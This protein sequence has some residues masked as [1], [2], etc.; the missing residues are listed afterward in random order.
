L[1]L[2]GEVRNSPEKSDFEIHRQDIDRHRVV[3][4]SGAHGIYGAEEEVRFDI[5]RGRPLQQE[6]D[7]NSL[8]KEKRDTIKS[9][10]MTGD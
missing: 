1:E 4:P 6:I 3:D 5:H 8:G 10:I 7:A 9:E 2:S